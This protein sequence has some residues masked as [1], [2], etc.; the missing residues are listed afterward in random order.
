MGNIKKIIQEVK[1]NIQNNGGIF[2]MTP[3]CRIDIDE[4]VQYDLHPEDILEKIDL[5]FKEIY[6]DICGWITNLST[7]TNSLP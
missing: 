1:S 5:P 7:D 2:D 4:N 6:I 3:N